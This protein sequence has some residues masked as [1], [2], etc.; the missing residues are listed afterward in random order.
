M[1]IQVPLKILL[2]LAAL[3]GTGF[4]NSMLAQEKVENVSRKNAI[5]INVAGTT[6]FIGIT[7]ERL[8]SDKINVEVG[9]GAV[10]VGVGFK[11]FPWP[12][13]DNKMVLH[14]GFSTNI[15]ATPFDT[16]GDGE[17]SSI[18][19]AMVGLTYFGKEGLNFSIDIGPSLNYD[20]TFNE[21]SFPMYGNL[22]IGYRF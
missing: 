5:S 9:L 2:V 18:S 8:L 15:F 19:Y 4:F 12:I 16:F 1:K 20:F 6:P 14:T 17:Y 10:S 13:S 21:T 11:Y 3:I 7:Y 22:K